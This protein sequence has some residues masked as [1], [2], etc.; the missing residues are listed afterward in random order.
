[1]LLFFC[2][3][4][5]KKKKSPQVRD[6]AGHQN[7]TDWFLQ[8]ANS[9]LSRGKFSISLDSS[10]RL[11]DGKFH[12]WSQAQEPVPDSNQK[13]INSL[14]GLN[15]ISLRCKQG[16]IWYF[17]NSQLRGERAARIRMPAGITSYFSIDKPTLLHPYSKKKLFPISGKSFFTYKSNSGFLTS[18]VVFQ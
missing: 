17:K 7:R 18:K 4:Q 16:L 2:P 13:S 14:K 15:P 12:P 10:H 6:P 9:I 8:L 5:K 11:P 3:G 1:M